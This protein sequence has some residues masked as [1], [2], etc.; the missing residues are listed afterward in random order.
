MGCLEESAL[1]FMDPIVSL[2]FKAESTDSCNT[3]LAIVW[4]RSPGCVRD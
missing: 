4:T 2:A 1:G 3:R